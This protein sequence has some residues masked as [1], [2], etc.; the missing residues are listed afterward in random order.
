MRSLTAPSIVTVSSTSAFGLVGGEVP[1]LMTRLAF[2]L[3]R[4]HR[5]PDLSI[6]LERERDVRL[7]ALLVDQGLG[8]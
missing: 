2:A 7:G 1:E 5:L 8:G 6:D 4:P 3:G